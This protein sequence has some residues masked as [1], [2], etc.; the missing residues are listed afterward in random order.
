L[1]RF[2]ALQNSLSIVVWVKISEIKY[3]QIFTDA[4]RV[5]NTNHKVNGETISVSLFYSCLELDEDF[6]VKIP[7]PIQLDDQDDYIVKYGACFIFNRRI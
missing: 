7:P 3:F 6:I 5:C 2:I 1:I 4:E